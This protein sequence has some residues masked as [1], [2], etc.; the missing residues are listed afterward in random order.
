LSYDNSYNWEFKTHVL[1]AGPQTLQWWLKSTWI[2]PFPT[3]TLD[4]VRFQVMDS[5]SVVPSVIR[6]LSF[7]PQRLLLLVA[8][9]DKAAYTLQASPDLQHWEDWTNGVVKNPAAQHEINL[10]NGPAR[11]FY[12]ARFE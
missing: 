4:E 5:P 2:H 11:T 3:L 6:S 12:R 9:K 8:G 7:R 1:P 10:E